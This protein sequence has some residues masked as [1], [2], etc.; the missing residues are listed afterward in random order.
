MQDELTEKIL[1]AAMKCILY[2]DLACWNQL[3]KDA[4]Y[5]NYIG[6]A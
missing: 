2:S 1:G 6:S 5:L 3:T 4:F